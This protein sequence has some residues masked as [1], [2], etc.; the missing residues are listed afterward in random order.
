[1][2]RIYQLVNY[3]RRSMTIHMIMCVPQVIMYVPYVLV[4]KQNASHVRSMYDQ[5]WTKPDHISIYVYIYICTDT[6]LGSDYGGVVGTKLSNWCW[7]SASWA[8][9][10]FSEFPT[11][12][13]GHK[14][15]S[16][17]CLGMFSI[18]LGHQKTWLDRRYPQNH[19]T[20]FNFSST[21]FETFHIFLGRRQSNNL[22]SNYTPTLT[23]SVKQ[24]W[25]VASKEEP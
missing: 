24:K 16:R 11:F 21:R 15:A 4:S 22:Q 17:P 12:Q 23:F 18:P 20:T 1:M 19:S 13:D 2:V 6:L 10:C 14:F 8:N 5:M 7:T 3:T 9:S 25:R